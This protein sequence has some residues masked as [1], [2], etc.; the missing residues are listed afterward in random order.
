[1]SFYQYEQYMNNM[2]T[3]PF[4]FNHYFLYLNVTMDLL[5]LLLLFILPL[6]LPYL[7]VLNLPI[8]IQRA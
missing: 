4:L 6:L 5:L 2:K 1:M 3:H 8:C 7:H